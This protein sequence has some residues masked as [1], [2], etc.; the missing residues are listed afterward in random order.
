[1]KSIVMPK[2]EQKANDQ[3]QEET[4]KQLNLE[5]LEIKETLAP[6]AGRDTRSKFTAVDMWNRQ[7]QS[8]SASEMIRRWNLN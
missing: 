5:T 1:M 8:R 3:L 6:P 4:K 2:T 7:R